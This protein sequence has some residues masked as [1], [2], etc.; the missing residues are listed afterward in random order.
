MASLPDQSGSPRLF[1]DGSWKNVESSFYVKIPPESYEVSDLDVRAKTDHYCQP[2]TVFGGYILHL[3]HNES[4]GYC[5]LRREESHAIGYSDHRANR[6][7]NMPSNQWVG[8][9]FICWTLPNGHVKLQA[10]I[11]TTGGLDGG[12]WSL[13]TED[14]DDGLWAGDG[15]GTPIFPGTHKESSIR[16]NFNG[17]NKFYE[18]KWW[19]IREIQPPT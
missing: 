3:R 11:D 7:L 10:W 12:I 8:I 16:A 9:K 5:T 18:I 1:V 13:L 17:A 6:P 14:I 19:S 15:G 4:P 2:D